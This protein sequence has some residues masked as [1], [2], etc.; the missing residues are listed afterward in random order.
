MIQVHRS[1]GPAPPASWQAR[2]EQAAVTAINGGR[3]HPSDEDVYG[4]VDARAA[5]ESLFSHKCA[6]CESQPTPATEWDV[7]H[8]RPKGR[9]AERPDHPGYYWLACSWDNLYLSCKY[10]N[11]RRADKPVTGDRQLRPPKGK[12]DQ[13]PLRDESTRA[14]G[15]SADLASE[16]RLLL[17]PCADDPERHLAVGVEGWMVVLDRSELGAMTIEVCN[18][19]R[20]RLRIARTKAI[21]TILE[22]I[23]N[24]HAIDRGQPLSPIISAVTDTLGKA[25]EPYALVARSIA[26]HPAGFGLLRQ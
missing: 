14:M 25:S 2:A 15:P 9:V 17:D 3:S 12:F 1:A 19:D 20:R 23:D 16:S 5:L 21:R 22:L 24:F 18:L 4:H 13:F 10:C 8:F 11:Q 26:S 7:E 6:Y